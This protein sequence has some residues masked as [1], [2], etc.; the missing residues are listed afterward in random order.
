MLRIDVYKAVISGTTTGVV[1][2]ENQDDGSDDD[3]A[4][5]EVEDM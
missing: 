4:N 3:E 5:T 2:G 1:P